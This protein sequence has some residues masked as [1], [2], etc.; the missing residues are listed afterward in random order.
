M[1]SKTR[2]SSATSSP[3]PSSAPNSA[4]NWK[5]CFIR[6][7]VGTFY[8]AWGELKKAFGGGD[9]GLLETAEQAEDEAVNA[10]DDA[11]TRELPLPVRQLLAK[12]AAHIQASHDYVKTARDSRK[13]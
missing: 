12:Q 13:K 1:K 10:Y 9:H 5:P 4:A 6:K 2:H 3:S 8:R 7:A 11:M